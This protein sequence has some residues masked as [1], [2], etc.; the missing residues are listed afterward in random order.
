MKSNQKRYENNGR[1][2]PCT[3]LSILFLQ[4]MNS[5]LSSMFW[6]E[7]IELMEVPPQFKS[8]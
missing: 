5:L 8:S 2:K 7:P 1:D 4:T 3:Q 6:S